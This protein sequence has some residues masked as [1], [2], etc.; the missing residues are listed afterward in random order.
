MPLTNRD[1]TARARRR[2]ADA[3][4]SS[5]SVL[6]SSRDT[7]LTRG[8]RAYTTRTA[9]SLPYERLMS[10]KFCARVGR[11]LG[12]LPGAVDVDARNDTVVVWWMPS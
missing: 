2:L 11:I 5:E 12:D 7:V 9:V 4:I 1:A 6:V 8:P 3:G 10:D